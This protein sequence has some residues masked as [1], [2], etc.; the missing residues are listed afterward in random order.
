MGLRSSD[1]LESKWKRTRLRRGFY[2][3]RRNDLVPGMIWMALGISVSIY[4]SRLRLGTLGGPGPGLM[5]FLLGLSL[6]I[7]SVLVITRSLVLTIREKGMRGEG[8]WSQVDLKKI[9]LVISS[10]LGYAFILEKIGFV[11]TTIVILFILFRTVGSQK[12]HYVL[13][14]S[15]LTV[16]V[17]YLVFVIILKVELPH[18]ILGRIR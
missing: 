10:L 7:C 16:F 14:S 9:I 4:S 11:I 3:L 2:L 1:C 12:W 5:P 6:C 18:G 17:T 8:V 13:V 15:L